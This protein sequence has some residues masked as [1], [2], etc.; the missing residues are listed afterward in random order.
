MKKKIKDIIPGLAACIFIAILG[1]ILGN[2]M[3]IIG[4]ASFA[5]ILGIIFGNTI[6]NKSKFDKGSKF[7]EKDLLSYS[8]VLMG[9]TISFMQISLLGFK[10]VLFIA[11]QMS[12]TIL[13]TYFIGKRL[14]F[15]KKYSLLM[16]SGNA[17]CGSSAI[18]SVSPV[19]NANDK[20]KA[21]SVTVVNLT[22]TILMFVIPIITTFLYRNSLTQTSAMVGG[23]LQSVGQVIASAKFINEDV[24]TLATI[25]K[26]IRII[27]LIFVVISFSRVKVEEN[28]DMSETEIIKREKKSNIQVPWY[29]IGFFI[30]CLINSLGLVP[31]LIQKTFKLISNNFE[32][33]ALAA[34]GMRVKFSDLIKEGPKSM[35]YGIIV[36]SFQILFAL[37][38]I[39]IIF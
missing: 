9:S 31:N 14:G 20:D 18:A 21:I 24:V 4:G 38:L 36:G 35:M 26:I 13:T 32:I 6:F 28:E 37:T 27:F 34:I 15:S 30:L 25:F 17:V 1:K 23:V 22:G 16:A 29:I 2:F 11:I 33:I 8:I 39:K 19:I 12:L 3:P 7:S 10:G 5:I